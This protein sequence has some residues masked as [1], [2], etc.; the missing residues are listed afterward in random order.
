MI[1]A[2]LGLLTGLGICRQTG[3]RSLRVSEEGQ[4]EV[5]SERQV[6]LLKPRPLKDSQ[7]E[8]EGEQV[9]VLTECQDSLF[10]WLVSYTYNIC[11]QNQGADITTPH[12]LETR[13]HTAT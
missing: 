13:P 10:L 6:R 4:A 7:W 11:I 5:E 12:L 9:Q 3:G 8:V 2:E 1:F